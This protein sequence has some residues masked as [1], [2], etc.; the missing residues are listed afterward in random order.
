M[1]TFM[2]RPIHEKSNDRSR[3]LV[4]NVDEVED[5]ELSHYR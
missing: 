3:D 2:D 5:I 1:Y 4:S